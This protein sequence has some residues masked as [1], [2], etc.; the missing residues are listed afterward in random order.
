M[1][2]TKKEWENLVTDIHLGKINAIGEGSFKKIYMKNNKVYTFEDMKQNSG[3]IYKLLNQLDTSYILK[4]NDIFLCANKRYLEMEYCKGDANDETGITINLLKDMDEK[5]FQKNFIGLE[6]AV[7][8]L[9][10]VNV[11]ALDVKPENMLINCGDSNSIVLTDLD[12]AIIDNKGDEHLT[13]DFFYSLN[14]SQDN[15]ENYKKNDLFAL[16][17][18]FIE[19]MNPGIEEAYGTSMFRFAMKSALGIDA[20]LN[21]IVKNIKDSKKIKYKELTNTYTDKLLRLSDGG[22]KETDKLKF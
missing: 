21:S 2:L 15:I 4:P 18:S 17:I 12:G 20:G 10:A 13:P 14:F 9:H 5:Q 19:I 22:E 16:Y 1:P 8:K 11:V 3:E 6:D 7:K